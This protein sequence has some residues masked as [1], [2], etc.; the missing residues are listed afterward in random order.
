MR[1]AAFMTIFLLVMPSFAYAAWAECNSTTSGAKEA[2]G[3]DV[4]QCVKIDGDYQWVRLTTATMPPQTLMKTGY[5]QTVFARV[6]SM[7]R[8]VL[9]VGYCG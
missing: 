4:F 3:N 6:F 7:V 1:L 8:S 5:F 9:G 2:I